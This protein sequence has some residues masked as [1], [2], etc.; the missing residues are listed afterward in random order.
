MK[1]LS[2][3]EFHG[4][5]NRTL[6][7]NGKVI[8]DT[9]YTQSRVDWHYHEQAYF[10]FI[11][12]G[13]VLEGNRKEIYHCTA[14]SLLFH[15]WQDPHYN[16]KPAGFTRG[17][18]IELDTKWFS[19]H[20]L[21]IESLTGSFTIPHPQVKLFMYDIVKESIHS[22][23]DSERNI[24]MLLTRIF[25]SLTKT[26]NA[27]SSYK[28]QWVSKIKEILTENTSDSLS[29]I[30][31]A[32]SIHIHPVHLSR[33]FHKYFGCNLG[34]YTRKKKVEKAIS[35]L[36]NPKK[37]LQDISY[38]CGFADQSHFIRNFKKEKGM[39]PLAF[40]KCLY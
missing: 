39:S 30:H 6:S 7:L 17:F 9:E 29:L 26:K 20:D 16:T 22:A 4:K 13:N 34:E 18:H 1:Q 5:T 12:Q 2:A 8:T 37:N 24:D 33:E 14:G 32:H 23:V 21:N 40:R 28:P 35:M 31:L 27:E 25:D 10:T 36:M 11:L 19:A 38:E 15:H 3:G